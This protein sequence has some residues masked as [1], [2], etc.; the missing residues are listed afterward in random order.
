MLQYLPLSPRYRLDDEGP[1]L[2]GID[3]NRHYWICVNGDTRFTVAIPGLVMTSIEQ[4]RE[5]ILSFRALQP[6]DRL[7]LAREMEACII[8]C[9]SQNCY[10][11]ESS[12][13][14]SPIWHLFDQETLDSLLMTGHPD[15]QCSPKDLDLGRRLL[16]R[17]WQQSV[18][19]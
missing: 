19:A 3:P 11:I 16:M 12:V 7:V 14:G 8:H 17:S 6:G 18:A 5:A 1:W 10:A 13:Q 2:E 15:W 4:F 9:I